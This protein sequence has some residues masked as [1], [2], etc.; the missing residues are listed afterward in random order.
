MS[1]PAWSNTAGAAP[2]SGI[3][4]RGAGGLLAVALTDV[5]SDGLSMVYSFFESG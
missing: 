2:D 3:N 4:G 1:R 5:L